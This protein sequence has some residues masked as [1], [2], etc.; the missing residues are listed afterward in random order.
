M[1]QD[2]AEF[3]TD[4]TVVY[5]VLCNG[6]VDEV[7]DNAPAAELH[8]KNLVKRRNIVR[9]IPKLVKSL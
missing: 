1:A 3:S 6:K 5:I 7:F 9:L 2:A 4:G 8:M